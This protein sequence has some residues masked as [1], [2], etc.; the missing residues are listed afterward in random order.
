MTFNVVGCVADAL[1]ASAQAWL[2][3]PASSQLARQRCKVIQIAAATKSTTTSAR[4]A[5]HSGPIYS[6]LS[7]VPEGGRPFGIESAAIDNAAECVRLL[8]ATLAETLLQLFWA[9]TLF[10]SA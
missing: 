2:I 7:C 1:A 9:Q 6:T 4:E 10:V 3:Q 5:P 8:S